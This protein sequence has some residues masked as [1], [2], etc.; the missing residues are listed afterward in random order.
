MK[1]FKFLEN[2][3]TADCAFLAFGKTKEE[4]FENAALALFEV[5]VETK[6]V[7]SIF[8]FQFSI[9]N[10][11]LEDLLFD[12]LSELVF[13]KDEKGMVFSKFEVKIEKTQA[14]GYQLQAEIWGEKID[15]Q[16]HNLKVD[17]KAVTR[18]LFKIKKEK[19][20]F[21][22]RVVLDI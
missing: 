10:L 22:A 20:K 5:M 19:D 8:N 12:F 17:V 7:R 11:N 2:I 1:A 16:R 14:P 4:L 3:A 18:H 13:L 15:S 9:F 21:T 6:K